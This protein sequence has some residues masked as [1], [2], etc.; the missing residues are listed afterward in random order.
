MTEEETPA[1]GEILRAAREA[2]GW[3]LS[4]TGLATGFSKPYLSKL[5]TGEKEVK[6]WHIAAYDKVFGGSSVRRRAVLIMGASFVSRAIWAELDMPAAPPARV[7][8]QELVALEASA[9]M[10]TGLGLRHGGRA[11]VA[12]ARGQLR[13]AAGLLDLDMPDS[14]RTTLMTTVGRLADRTAWSMADS[15]QIKQ[16][17]KVYDFALTVTPDPAQHWLTL[18]NLAN[19]RIGESQPQRALALLDRDDPGIPV[20]R[21]LVRSTRAHAYAQ[22]GDFSRTV[23][24]VADADAAHAAVDLS[25][26]PAAVDPYVSGHA[27]HAHSA[28]GRAL[29]VLACSGRRKASPLASQ[30]LEAAV[31]AFGV[32][33]ARAIAS[34]QRRL[35]VLCG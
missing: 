29:Y 11:A 23:R 26:L 27:A 6:P 35:R 12:A 30:R 8:P 2:A 32:E 16:A 13:Y 28:A 3:S 33:R 9:D 21:F 15:G 20:L 19:L 7:D 18:V 22:L 17:D 24:N 4:R 25:D 14:V 1:L 34:C 31:E 5:E 10:L